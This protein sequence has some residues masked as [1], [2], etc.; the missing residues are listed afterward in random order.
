MSETDRE[1]LKNILLAINDKHAIL[2]VEKFPR[3]AVDRAEG[4]RFSPVPPPQ[5]L[6]KHDD[7]L[8]LHPE[9]GIVEEDCDFRQKLID[10]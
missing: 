4:F 9:L 5:L 1:V 8:I 3:E 7:E 2:N 6:F 10:P